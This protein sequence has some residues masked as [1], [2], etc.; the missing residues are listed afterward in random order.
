ML[1]IADLGDRDR[2]REG[3]GAASAI[4]DQTDRRLASATMMPAARMGRLRGDSASGLYWGTGLYWTLGLPSAFAPSFSPA[5][6]VRR[7][8]A[9]S[10]GVARRAAIIASLIAAAAAIPMVWA[11]KP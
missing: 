5:I 4:A 9:T 3:D 11:W 1:D 8:L 2:G 10:A 6:Q 7:W